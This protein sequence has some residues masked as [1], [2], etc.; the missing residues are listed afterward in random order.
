MPNID[1]GKLVGAAS[2]PVAL[3][4]ATSIFLSNLGAKYGV[5]CSTFRSVAE[6]FRKD[7]KDT[8][9]TKGLTQQL[10]LYSRRL[11]ILIRATFWLGLS[12]LCFILTVFFTGVSVILPKSPVWP[13]ITAVMSFSGMLILGASVLM[14]LHENHLAKQTALWEV[15]EYP[16]V[17]SLM[18]SQ[19]REQLSDTPEV[20]LQKRAA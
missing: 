5:L 18:E 11:D 4:I 20:D 13:I 2:A 14:E 17:V 10:R 1:V 7:G 19:H 8:D 9:R 6:Q 3:I 15:S 12:I 16:K